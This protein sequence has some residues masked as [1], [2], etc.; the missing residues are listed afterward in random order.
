MLKKLLHY[1]LLVRPV[2]WRGRKDCPDL[3]ILNPPTVWIEVKTLTGT[4][5]DSQSREHQTMRDAGAIVEVARSVE[6]VDAIVRR[7]YPGAG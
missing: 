6:A 5:R 7:H 3:V 2:E 1:G 4:V